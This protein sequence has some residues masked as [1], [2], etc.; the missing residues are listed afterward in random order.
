MDCSLWEDRQDP[1]TRARDRHVARGRGVDSG[2]DCGDRRRRTDGGG[3]G[4]ESSRRRRKRK[5]TRRS[6]EATRKESEERERLG[7]GGRHK[8]RDTAGRGSWLQHTR[9]RER[10]EREPPPS[11]AQRENQPPRRRLS[12]APP[13]HRPTRP[14]RPCPCRGAGRLH[15]MYHLPAVPVPYRANNC[16]NCKALFFV[17][18]VLYLY[19]RAEH[20][21]PTL[22]CA[23]ALAPVVGRGQSASRGRQDR[24]SVAAADGPQSVFLLLQLEAG[25]ATII[26]LIRYNAAYPYPGVQV[27]NYCL[28][29]RRA[30]SVARVARSL[31][32]TPSTAVRCPSNSPPPPDA[33]A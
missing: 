33:D 24:E 30:L 23:R 20:A 22:Q 21:T 11:P 6:E 26:P 9:A 12:A 1:T 19:T 3:A 16:I 13:V 5:S 32:G 2:T 15:A 18:V 27:R 17:A 28:F 8:K 29:Q 7:E 31:A 10:K 25:A 14:G 4:G